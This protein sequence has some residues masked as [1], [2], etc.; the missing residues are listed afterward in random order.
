[1]FEFGSLYES[2]TVISSFWDG[3]WP[4]NAA[5]AYECSAVAATSMCQRGDF[6]NST[7]R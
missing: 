3:R 6:S 5:G 1:V 7:A 4:R 2:P